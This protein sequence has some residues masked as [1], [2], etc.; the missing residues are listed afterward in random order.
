GA[1]AGEAGQ[2]PGPAEHGLDA[3]AELARPERFGDVV[4]GAGVQPEE[5]VDLGGAAGEHDQIRRGEPP[6]APGDFQAVDVRQGDVERGDQRIVGT[7]Q[8]D[9]VGA[10]GRGV[11]L[12]T[13]LRQRGLEQEA[14]VR[15]VLDHDG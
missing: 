9:A 12:E 7:H 8:L 2:R 10:G 13:R 11:Y 4:V 3:G 5:R 6:H 15:V 14:D 1:S